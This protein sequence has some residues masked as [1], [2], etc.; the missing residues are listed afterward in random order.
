MERIQIESNTD[1]RFGF[2]TI[3]IVRTDRLIPTIPTFIL[4]KS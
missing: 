2:P 3:R 1:I 4:N